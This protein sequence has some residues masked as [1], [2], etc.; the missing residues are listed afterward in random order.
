MNHDP[1]LLPER[2]AQL[3]QRCT[4]WE[5]TCNQLQQR[6]AR[7][8]RRLRLLGGLGLASLAVALFA[9]PAT[10]AAAQSGYG[11]TI[12]SL[13]N[14]TQFITVDNGQMYV[15]GT[16][17]HIE[18]GLG[19]TNGKPADPYDRVNPPVVNGLGNLIVGY[20]ALRGGGD[21][22]GGSH[23]LVLGD[24][25]N[26]SSYGGLVAGSFN[27]ITGPYC[28]V[29]GGQA[30]TASSFSSSVSGGFFNTA[31]GASSSVSGGAFNDAKGD[32]A[33]VSGG[34]L[35]HASAFFSSVSG[36]ESNTA[37]AN[38]SSVSGGSQ[39]TASGDY[40]SVS[41]GFNHNQGGNTIW[42][43]GTLVSGP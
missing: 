41:G 33:S 38:F 16:N 21:L 6:C 34:D 5:A 19:A 17:L 26:Y 32:Y 35:N 3:E 11:A 18:N 43:G 22:R 12:N 15:R 1:E 23:N 2:L 39:N 9:S 29:S 40:S 25:S 37:G 24:G 8:E 14:K 28:S 42:Q 7:S 36:G 30:N 13:I 4:R 31:T 10:R 27:T 20:N